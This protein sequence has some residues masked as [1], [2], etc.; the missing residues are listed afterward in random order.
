MQAE[1]PLKFLCSAIKF[2]MKVVD[3]AENYWM[4]W[5][6]YKYYDRRCFYSM[7]MTILLA[8]FKFIGF[9]VANLHNRMFLQ[10]ADVYVFALRRGGRCLPKACGETIG[11]LWFKNSNPVKL[12]LERKNIL[13]SVLLQFA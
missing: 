3:I 10:I 2:H 11:Y 1:I 5:K 13:N 12:S 8:P 7:D 9:Q 4:D 6:G